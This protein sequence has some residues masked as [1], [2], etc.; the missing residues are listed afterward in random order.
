MLKDTVSRVIYNTDLEKSMHSGGSSLEQ[1]ELSATRHSILREVAKW[2]VMLHADHT[3]KYAQSASLARPSRAL[4][5]FMWSCLLRSK[6]AIGQY[7][8]SVSS[9]ITSASDIRQ[10][11]RL[12]VKSS[13]FASRAFIM[14]CIPMTIA[15]SSA[16]PLQ[17]S[18]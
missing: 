14:S 6:R 2:C 15:R 4:E 8:E 16:S 18:L 1:Y 12:C 10:L 17:I 11:V 3:A 9:G 5:E 13:D 7:L